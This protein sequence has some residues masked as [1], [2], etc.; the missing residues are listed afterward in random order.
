[1]QRLFVRTPMPRT[2]EAIPAMDVLSAFDVH[3]RDG[4]GSDGRA[5]KPGAPYASVAFAVQP[6]VTT[7]GPQFTHGLDH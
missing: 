2:P 6:L 3:Q 4:L 5:F 7:T 1:M